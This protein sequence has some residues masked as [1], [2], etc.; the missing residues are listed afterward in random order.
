MF[1][2]CW[3]RRIFSKGCKYLLGGVSLVIRQAVV[4][5]IAMG[6][7]EKRCILDETGDQVAKKTATAY[8]TTEMYC[9]KESQQHSFGRSWYGAPRM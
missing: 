5:I 1:C 4:T 2:R 6:H 9:R 3:K 7:V 8:G